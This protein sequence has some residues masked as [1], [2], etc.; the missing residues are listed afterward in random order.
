[1]RN[2][3]GLYLLLLLFLGFHKTGMA[4]SWNMTCPPTPQTI[5]TCEGSFYDN[6]GNGGNYSANQNCVYTFCSDEV[7]LCMR[8]EFEDLNIQ[9]EDMFGNVYDYLE[10]FDGPTTA[11][12]LLYYLY[13]GPFP[14]T[15]PTTASNGCLTFH[16]VSDG[17]V[18]RF[19]WHGE[20]HCMNCPIPH[21]PLQ[22]DCGGAIPLCESQIYQPIPYSG[23]NGSNLIPASSCLTTGEVNSTWYVF[24]SQ[25]S[26]LFSF[27]LS[28][29]IFSD[30][31]N[32]AVYDITDNGCAGIPT[33]LSP[34]VSCNFSSN[35]TTWNGQTG[36]DPGGPYNGTLN[37]QGSGGTAFNGGIPINPNVTYAMVVTNPSPLGGYYIDLEPSTAA[38]EDGSDPF[39]DSIVLVPCP[40]P[41]L[42]IYFSEPIKCNTINASDFTIT[43]GPPV[44]VT[45]AVGVNCTPL[46]TYTQAVVL[47]LS[48]G[49]SGGNYNVNVVSTIRDLCGNSVPLNVPFAF[50]LNPGADAGSDFTVCGL[51]T[52]MNAINPTAGSGIWSQISSSS[53]GSTI[54]ANNADPGTGITVSQTGV[55]TY[56]WT[57]SNG[58][59]V[60]SDQITVTFSTG[61]FT[62]INYGGSPYCK[63]QAG[64][65]APV[66]TG[67]TGGSFSASPAGLSINPFSG[68]VTP[69]TSL[70]GLY[71]ISYLVPAD[72]ACPAYTV[73]Q[74]IVINNVPPNPTL[75]PLTPCSGGN[76]SF[77]SG[78]GAIY[79]FF[80]NGISQTIPSSNNNV[81]LGPLNIGDQICVNSYPPIPFNFNGLIS[82]QE[83][84]SPLATSAGGPPTSGFGAG[85]NM[86]AIF[87]KNGSGYLF[88]AIA[89]NLVNNS[90]NRILLFIDCQAGGFNNLG[91]WVARSNAP[92][93][94]VENLSNSITF[95][96]GFSPEYVL[97]MN[98]ATANSYFDLYNMVTN[99]NNYLGDG[100]TSPWLGFSPNSG[101]G[102][103]T[104]GF[105]FAFPINLLGNPSGSIKVFAMLVNDPGLG[106][107]TNLS[108][109]FLTRANA[110]E[111][112]YGNAAVNF[113]AAA[114]NPISYA[115]SADCFAQTCVTVVNSVTPSFNPIAPICS[116]DPSPLLSNLSLNGITG[117]WS[118]ALVNNTAS[119]SYTFTPNLGQ[120]ASSVTITITVEPTPNLSPLYHD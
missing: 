92:Y 118:P 5:N 21:T 30:D 65:F 42:T 108:N 73:N 101:V 82:E 62:S 113:G 6:G 12:P 2:Y 88:G 16:F 41:T 14:A 33:G 20:I 48:A 57:V 63:N 29:N 117:T 114:P 59:C 8:M 22:Q 75:T 23:N 31:F 71:I 53:G 79:E 87:L 52:L 35:T 9:D 70:A 109:Q 38:Y 47:T 97:A 80:L 55:Y 60:S 120:C 85:N 105:E 81:S 77:T 39:I 99:S 104:K 44:T 10:V 18:Q 78:N 27:V 76:I 56:Q 84:G 11:S 102:D 4:Q 116:G 46:N 103:F 115:I 28:P 61:T 40:T 67:L 69:S 64:S 25:T 107:P 7:G 45:S 37:F 106:N 72:G 24:T 98:Q 15:L 49:I 36:A 58:T 43:G 83:W 90:N 100:N 91:A 68:M 13:G 95:D 119:A 66:I 89:G 19:G 3:L 50:T 17:S 54:F 26:G 51:S 94:S 96:A 93:W 34:E 74:T 111:L 32:F 86:D 112:N 110:A 1:M